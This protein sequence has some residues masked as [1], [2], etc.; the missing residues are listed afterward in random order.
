MHRQ[1]RSRIATIAA[2]FLLVVASPTPALADPPPAPSTGEPASESTG[3]PAAES[4]KV[5]SGHGAKVSKQ[6]PAAGKPFTQEE[7]ERNALERAVE[8]DQLSYRGS[9]TVDPELQ[10]RTGARAAAVDL[11][12]TPLPNDV[13]DCLGASGANTVAGRVHNRFLYCV[14]RTVEV[15]YWEIDNKGVPIEEEGTSTID[16]EVVAYGSHTGRTIRVFFR[17]VADS[18]SYDWGFI[19]NR[20]KAPDQNLM[21]DVECRNNGLED[22]RCGLSPGPEMHTFEEWDE[23]P[24]WNHWDITSAKPSASENPGDFAWMHEWRLSFESGPADEFRTVDPGYSAL[25]TIRCDSATYFS[26]QPEACVFYNVVPHLTYSTSD[27]GVDV[28][29]EHIKEAQDN[30]NNTF[31]LVSPVRD[32]V[33]PGKFVGDPDE[34][35]LHRISKHSTQYNDNRDHKNG[36]CYGRGPHAALYAGLGLPTRPVSGQDCDE[37][38]F[39]S[40][41]EG[42]ASP[43]WDFSVRA[44]DRGKNRRAGSR[45]GGYYQAD[46]IL[47]DRDRFW[48]EIISGGGPFPT[49]GGAVVD[50]GPDVSGVE[51]SQIYLD[52]SGDAAEEDSLTW[53][54]D[55]PCSFA[56]A[57]AATTYVT[58]ADD[59]VFT[60]TLTSDD[61]SDE[62]VS[63]DTTVTVGNAPPVLTLNGPDPWQLFKVGDTVTVDAT[64]TDAGAN[65]THTCAIGWDDGTDDSYGA[66]AGSCGRTHRFTRAG[67]FTLN[68]AVTDDDGA[69]DSASVMIVVYDPAAG[70]VNANGSV[71]SPAGSYGAASGD[72]YFH[73]AARYYNDRVPTGEARAWLND[74]GF[75]FGT[76]GDASLEWL[77]VTPDRR[78]AAKGTGL[79]DGRRHGFVFY[80]Y[81]EPDRFR[82]VVWDLTTGSYPGSVTVYDN[83]RGAGYDVDV[84][85]PRALTSGI[86]T[87]QR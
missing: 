33:I 77:V 80:G 72:G 73:L 34:Q 12:T 56:D 41:K 75:R 69:S 30:P 58:C 40:T 76:V 1:S 18:A 29:A 81:D 48:V 39:R 79:V 19:D 14:K 35:P 28:V 57:H 50:A 10:P 85:D 15:E 8:E 9:E 82:M 38:P 26:G 3:E 11:P 54:I 5:G 22:L 24:D 87:I 52:G 27:P 78:I 70:F 6:E 65:D 86:V 62:A 49:P 25:R 71:P 83:Q 60:A 63:D 59:G 31:P 7:M 16:V 17:T 37:Y 68:V 43:D 36:A 2:A 47:H 13:S 44:L 53:T 46:R 67:M 42:A 66:S 64:F 61:G 23:G 74:A 45:L 21:V 4:I 55:G 32:K 84:A 51:G 20:L